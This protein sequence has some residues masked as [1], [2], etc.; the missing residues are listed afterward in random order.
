MARAMLNLSDVRLQFRDLADARALLEQSLK[1]FE[2]LGMRWDMVYVIE[3]L[4]GMAAYDGRPEDAAR[5]IG[6]ADRAREELGTPL[7]EGE[8]VAYNRY[9]AAAK[10]AL[11]EGGFAAAWAEGR[12]LSVEEAAAYALSS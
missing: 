12:A 6:A 8:K 4:G 2:Q 1:M 10:D 9:L 3:N 7:P 11:G 5:L